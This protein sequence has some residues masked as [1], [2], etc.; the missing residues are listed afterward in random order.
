MIRS[1]ALL[2]LVVVALLPLCTGC[3]DDKDA[4]MP[5]NALPAITPQPAVA[6][7]NTFGFSLFH[8][9]TTDK[10]QN[11]FISPTSLMLALAMT[12]NGA[13]GQT[14]IEMAKALQISGIPV[15][16]LNRQ[17]SELQKDLQDADRDVQ[18][19]IANSIWASRN[20]RLKT[21][22]A[23]LCRQSYG[24]TLDTLDFGSPFA[25]IA[26]NRWANRKTHGAIRTIVR[27]NELPQTALLLLDAVYFKGKWSNPFKVKSTRPA[28]FTLLGGQRKTVQMM[29]RYGSYI[30]AEDG[31]LQAVALPYGTGRMNMIVLLP[32]DKQGLP[33]LLKAMDDTAWRS[34]SRRMGRL[35]GMVKLPRFQ[36]AH[37]A[38]LD[39]ALKTLGMATALDHGDFSGIADNLPGLS[40]VKQKTYL[41][42]TEKKTEAAA[43]SLFE[44]K[45]AE[46]IAPQPFQMIVDHPFLLGIV[47][48]KTGATLFLGA[49]VDPQET[50]AGE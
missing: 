17:L 33:A 14:K 2:T 44:M 38:Q 29:A 27:A 1:L 7:S 28:E 12:Y 25:A 5:P 32:R 34:L 13:G 24:A 9:L 20:Y 37:E 16:D 15:D 10:P 30:Y 18:V 42:V 22:F 48:T 21:P 26:I 41:R 40:R 8:K 35:E 39:E 11:V 23:D 36:I 3:E 50:R 4:Y 19:Q 46:S 6:A 43:I 49:I 31:G 45:S 47:D